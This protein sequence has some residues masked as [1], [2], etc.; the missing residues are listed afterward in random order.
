MPLSLGRIAKALLKLVLGLA[1]LFAATVAIGL[2]LN[3]RAER[4]AREFCAA[5]P[6]SSPVAAAIARADGMKLRHYAN[7]EGHEHVFM[8]P[9]WVFNWANCR[10]A[11]H[12][13]GTVARA[14]ATEAED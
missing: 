11:L 13:D 14:W 8:F 5:I 4:A 10:V 3:S 7:R 6:P 1:L 9:G 2:H 12:P